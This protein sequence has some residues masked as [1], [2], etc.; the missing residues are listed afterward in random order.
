MILDDLLMVQ[1]DIAHC[2]DT[3]SVSTVALENVTRTAVDNTELSFTSS[4][5]QVDQRH[6][7][8]AEGRPLQQCHNRLMKCVLHGTETAE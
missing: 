3:F 8:T 7:K 6:P 5:K 2:K 1:R 4:L